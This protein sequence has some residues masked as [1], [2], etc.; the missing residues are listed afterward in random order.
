MPLT[1]LLLLP[2]ALAAPIP[3]RIAALEGGITS[4]DLFVVGA[5]VHPLSGLGVWGWVGPADL[6][7]TW[8]AGLGYT[9]RIAQWETE[10]TSWKGGLAGW[11]ELRLGPGVQ[12]KRYAVSF[13]VDAEGQAM[14]GFARLE[15]LKHP[16]PHLAVQSALD[17]GVSSF[18]PEPPAA[19]R[20]YPYLGMRV[21]LALT[22]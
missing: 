4:S 14:D 8:G 6:L 16:A 15:V 5:S 22:R 2:A 13:L 1:V 18:D 21:G 19:G 17:L 20:I 12:Y 9:G 10:E 3:T 11:N 7:H